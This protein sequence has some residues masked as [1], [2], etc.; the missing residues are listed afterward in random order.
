VVAAVCVASA[1]VSSCGDGGTADLGGASATSDPSAPGS[2]SVSDLPPALDEAVVQAHVAVRVSELGGEVD[3]TTIVVSALAGEAAPGIVAFAAN[4][5]GR[6]GRSRM[7]GIVD[8]DGP[9]SRPLVA[10]G[11]VFDRWLATGGLPDAA[12]A[13]EVVNFIQGGGARQAVLM[14]DE[15]VDKL[16]KP[17]WREVAATPSLVEV[18]GRPGVEY[19]LQ[20]RLG[21]A[22]RRVS[23]K[24]GG[25]V[26]VDE[27]PVADVLKGK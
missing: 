26:V 13:A 2:T 11:K 10:V 18:K 4:Y 3:P 25:G 23:A 7:A 22:R 1:S 15:A 6:A 5:E 16:P 17:E 24:A 12:R 14:T 20:G 27:H 8:A 19:W 21:L 9:D